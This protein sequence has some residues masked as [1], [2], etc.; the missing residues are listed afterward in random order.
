MRLVEESERAISS[1]M[2]EGGILGQDLLPPRDETVICI[3]ILLKKLQSVGPS[4]SAGSSSAECSNRPFN[5]RNNAVKIRRRCR[6]L[7]FETPRTLVLLRRRKPR[8]SNRSNLVFDPAEYDK[9][10]YLL[11]LQEHADRCEI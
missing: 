8:L 10:I 6:I 4:G 3:T 7:L 5:P 1:M 9:Y 2:V 11:S